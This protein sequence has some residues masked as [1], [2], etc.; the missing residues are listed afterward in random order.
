MT[1]SASRMRYLLALA[2]VWFSMPALASMGNI[3]TN[4]GLVPM[5]VASAQAFSM[6]NDQVSATYYNPAYLAHDP[7]GELTLGLLQANNQ[8]KAASV[9]GANPPVRNGDLIQDAPAQNSLVGMKTNLAS[10]T[11]FNHPIYLGFMAGIEKYGMEMLAFSSSTSK[12]GQYLKYGRQPLFLNIGGATPI[13]R[14]IDAGFSTRITLHADA[15]LV[16]QT[17]LAGNTQYEKLNVNAR[18]SFRPIFG[19]NIDWGDTLCPDHDCWA[20]GWDTAFAYRTHSS[21]RTAVYANTVI[22]GTIP[23]PGLTLQV[24]TLDSYQPDI[25]EAAI[26]YKGRGIR[27]ALA[28]EQQRWSDLTDRFQGD[29][30]KNQANAQFKDVLVPRAAVQVD[31]GQY[32][33]LTTGVAYQ[34]SPLES[35]Q[36]LDVNYFDNNEWILGVGAS[37]VFP[38]A[39]FLRYPLEI[40]L[41]YQHHFLKPR[42]FQMTYSSAPS[43][44]YETVTAKGSID[45]FSG[46]VTLKF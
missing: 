1:K 36:T 27:A 5:D 30:V 22:P 4:Y 3:A 9:G 8:L 11:T 7:R 46:S 29:T 20:S 40:D 17:D 2:G 10:L 14:G 25:L 24:T 19:L 34:K 23:A 12:T 44:P 35:N 26:Q 31:L 21:Y 33:H 39:P 45:V 28:V 32:I 6:F 13:W 37:A 41:G 38:E 43:N 18:P 42:D 16:A 15:A